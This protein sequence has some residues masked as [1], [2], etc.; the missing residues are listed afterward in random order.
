MHSAGRLCSSN[1]QQLHTLN[2]FTLPTTQIQ[3]IEKEAKHLWTNETL[4]QTFV[5]QFLRPFTKV[6]QLCS[7]TKMQLMQKAIK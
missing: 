2:D 1:C 5:K 4:Q 7:E 6:V 3:D